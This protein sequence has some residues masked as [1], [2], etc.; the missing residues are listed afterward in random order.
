MKNKDIITKFKFFLDLDKELAYIN[1]MNK[2]GWKLVY[3]KWGCFYTFTKT[4]PDEYITILHF[5]DKEK[6]SG[7]TAFAAQCG[8]ETIPHTMDGLGETLYLTGKKSEVSEDFVND[9]EAKIHAQKKIFKKFFVL[10][11]IMLLLNLI[12]IVETLICVGSLIIYTA[13]GEGIV[14]SDIPFI[15]LSAFFVLFTIAYTVLSCFITPPTARLY[16]KIKKLEKER[17]IYE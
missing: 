17:D 4:E 16:Q 6:I 5:E 7:V 14:S 8:Y 3:I 9:I 12:L 2:N 13:Y 15:I 1:E 10:T 11:C